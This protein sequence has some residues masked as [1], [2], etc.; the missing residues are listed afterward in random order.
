[1]NILNRI[2]N[3]A[4]AGLAAAT[5]ALSPGVKAE[6]ATPSTI[7]AEEFVTSDFSTDTRIELEHSGLEAAVEHFTGPDF[8]DHSTAIGV[9]TPE[10]HGFQLRQTGIMSYGADTEE[11][12]GFASNLVY[13]IPG[14]D[15]R[16]GAGGGA[17]FPDQDWLAHGTFGY[18][19]DVLHTNLGVFHHEG[20]EWPVDGRG[21]ASIL[22]PGGF[23]MSAG[24]CEGPNLFAML[25]Y[26]EGEGGFNVRNRNWL[27]LESLGSRHD[28]MLTWNSSRDRRSYE[29][30]NRFWTNVEGEWDML[31]GHYDPT[32]GFAPLLGMYGEYDVELRFNQDQSGMG[33]GASFAYNPGNRNSMVQ[34]GI[35]YRHNFHD[36]DCLTMDLIAGV[37]LDGWLVFA[38]ATADILN[39]DIAGLVYVGKWFDL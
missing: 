12:G 37:N 16:I 22:V 5:I 6:E 35:D 39:Q 2:K 8:D 7:S 21:Y 34:F 3:Y 36:E 27:D 20:G 9:R 18:F 19:G 13:A 15:L 4:A 31:D 17:H 33:G 29:F 30:Q 1:M 24:K 38:G 26:I 28:V 32:I 10:L 25:G 23:Y 11:N 14:T